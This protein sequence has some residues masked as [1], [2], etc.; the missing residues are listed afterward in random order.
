M[1]T[2]ALVW[3]VALCS[4]DL[5]AETLQTQCAHCAVFQSFALFCT[6][7]PSP[8]DSNANLAGC[9]KAPPDCSLPSHTVMPVPSMSW[10]SRSSDRATR[11]QNMD[12]LSV[13]CS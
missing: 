4:C 12:M 8:L 9:L 1:F 10:G 13:G 6:F 2:F 7:Q 3:D 5:A 11:A